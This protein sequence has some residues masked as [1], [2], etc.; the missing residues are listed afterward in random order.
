MPDY[1]KSKIYKIESC[2]TELIYVGS[3]TY[4]TLKRRM[5]CHQSTTKSISSKEILKY[6][7]ARIELI[8]EFPCSSREE[9][10]QRED[11][12]IRHFGDKVVNKNNAVRSKEKINLNNKRFYDNHHDEMLQ[13]A[14]EYR[15]RVGKDVLHQADKEW[16]EANAEYNK[17][18]QATYFAE[19]KAEL[20]EKHKA[21]NIPIPCPHCQKMISKYGLPRHINS[22]HL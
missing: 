20:Q 19:N 17:E 13:R 2:K 7:D 6:A 9:L 14:K 11:Y 22:L 18:R 8:E 10:C 15:E 5:E 16:R 3:T 1:Q 12:W 4:E 21:R